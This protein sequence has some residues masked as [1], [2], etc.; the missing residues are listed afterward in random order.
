MQT[1][2]PVHDPEG[3]AIMFGW[4]LLAIVVVVLFWLASSRLHLTPSE[5]TEIAILGAIGL[6]VVVDVATY[7][8]RRA[9]RLAALWPPPPF[10]IA[11]GDEAKELGLAQ[12]V[13]SVLVGHESDGQPFYWNNETRVQQTIA[14]GMTGAGKTTLIESILQQDICR[15]VPI[16]FIDGKGEKKV[17]DRILPIVEAAGRMDGF[18][19]I[20]IGRAHV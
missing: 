10:R 13:D 2:K 11:F 19:L 9:A 1:E 12:D 17:L 4:F 3:S 14:S 8:R 15:G 18:R 5:L 20:E 6:F 7:F 16:I